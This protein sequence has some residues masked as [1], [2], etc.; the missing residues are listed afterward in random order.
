MKRN[1][2]FTSAIT[3]RIRGR[4]IKFKIQERNHLRGGTGGGVE[5]AG[6]PDGAADVAEVGGAVLTGAC[7]VAT[8]SAGDTGC[9]ATGA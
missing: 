6:A 9:I 2:I 7:K 8:V 5:R 3:F 4:K 1:K